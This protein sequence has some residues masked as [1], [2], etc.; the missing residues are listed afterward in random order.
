ADEDG[1]EALVA[2]A[3]EPCQRRG[4]VYGAVPGAERAGE[5]TDDPIVGARKR[6]RTRRIGAEVIDVGTPFH[7]EDP[8]P[9]DPWWQDVGRRGD[10]QVGAPAD[11][12]APAPHRFDEQRPVEARLGR[13]RVVD[14]RGVDLERCGDAETRGRQDAFTAEVVV[15]LDYDVGADTAREIGEP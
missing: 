12:F 7:F 6:H 5:Y 8:A 11:R 9:F 2:V 10:E 15:A 1:A 13:S 3:M 4:Q 14:D